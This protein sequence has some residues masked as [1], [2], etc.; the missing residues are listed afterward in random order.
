MFETAGWFGE[1]GAVLESFAYVTLRT[2]R[3]F[4]LLALASENAQRFYPEMGTLYL[5]RLGELTSTSLVR[6]L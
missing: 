5:K 2:D 3:V 6:F 1:T 4:G